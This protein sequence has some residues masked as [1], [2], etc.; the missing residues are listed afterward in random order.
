M[1][2]IQH[3]IVGFIVMVILWQ[4]FLKRYFMLEKDRAAWQEA[5]NKFLR[6]RKY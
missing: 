4:L 6:D 3:A 2:E 1:T 5:I